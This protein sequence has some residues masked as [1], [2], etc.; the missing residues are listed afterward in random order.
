MR[1]RMG[2]YSGLQLRWRVRSTILNL[3]VAVVLALS[4]F[5]ALWMLLTSFKTRMEAFAMPPVWLFL[6][7]GDAYLAVFR[8]QNFVRY[9]INSLIVCVSTT[10][11]ALVTGTVAAYAFSVFR[12]PWRNS[13]LIG[14]IALR[15][16][17][18]IVLVVPIYFLLHNVGLLDTHLA[19]ILAYTTFNVPF[20]IWMLKG[21]FDEVPRD[22]IH[23]SLIDG[24]SHV[25]GLVRI[26]LPLVLPGLFATSAF[27]F[28]LSWNDF[29]FA[30]LL[31][32]SNATTL[33]VF[34]STFI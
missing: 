7:R 21:F 20:V 27:T 32:S 15:M 5:P 14:V 16:L 2:T 19:L 33:P 22:L 9:L 26:A 24:C 6:P 10:A 13:L 11:L 12:F 28:I 4:L 29:L 23:A 25:S 31:T 3:L 1:T 30:L 18:P 34:A 17:P 8:D